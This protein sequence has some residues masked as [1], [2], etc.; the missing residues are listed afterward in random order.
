MKKLLFILIVCIYVIPAFAQGKLTPE[1]LWEFNRISD[2]RL[3]PDGSTVAYC[4]TNYDI[5]TNKRNTDI[6][7]V[8]VKDK[9]VQR[10]TDFEG[11]EFSPRWHPGGKTI[12]FLATEGGT[13]QLWITTTDGKMKNQITEIE[14]G[15]NSYEFSP[16]GTHIFYTK[17]IKL[18]KTT[19]EIY[20]DLPLANVKI[21][22]DL[23]YR[24][25]NDWT[26]DAY[27]HIFVADY[28]GK[29]IFNDKDIM[30]GEKW[31]SPLSPFF[32]E[33][34]ICWSPDGKIVAYTCKKLRG[35]DYAIST[36][37]D[38]YLYYLETGKTVNITQGMK[39][40]DK[41]PV[42]TPDSKKVTW[43]SME[44]PGYESDKE[45]L[46]IY[47][48]GSGKMN[49]LTKDFDRNV[50]N[51][52]WDDDGKTLYF[53]S[54]IN[55]TF[56]IWKMD[57][58]T[59]E[60]KQV[61][62]GKHNYSS[63]EKK[64]D[65]FIAVKESMSKAREVYILNE[66]DGTDDQLTFAN[67][68]IYEKVK[69]G[70]VEER[71]VKTTDGKEMLVWVIYPPDFDAQKKYPALLYCQGGP[72]GAVSQRF[73]YRWNY[74]LMAAH[75]YIIIAPNRRGLPTFGSEW[76]DQICGDYGGQNIKDYLSAVDEIKKEP[77]V[78]E[79]RLGAIGASYGGY[80]VFWLAGHHEK[81]FKAFISHCGL[82]NLESF[83]G[84][85][86]ESFFPNY[87]VGGA[88]WEDPAPK[89][90]NFSPHKYVQNWDTPILI[91]TGEYDFRVPYTESL[92]AFNAA[93]LRDVP[94]KLL[95]F[96]DETHFVAKPQN[97]I[98]WNREFFGW[99]DKWLK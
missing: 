78:D 67:K 8:S 25:W 74:Q 3:S 99:L 51:V 19:N 1:I 83:Y 36:N 5:K 72:H 37:S 68:D 7:L 13:V 75:G 62:K 12:S 93:R 96:P 60:I 98:L 26:D 56:Q 79:D 49:Y 28:D 2:A 14:G 21:I 39:G 18:E 38:I 94:A 46:F 91:I 15:I 76:N 24:H 71:W 59:L 97:S 58:S 48:L 86:E 55:A 9:S 82:F 33:S 80:S 87:D 27:S 95:Y 84:A 43:L 85:T 88:Y 44:T 22:N 34:E 81:R 30:E 45:R 65:V 64:G 29:K 6:F 20:P 23:M 73:H 54:G 35:R 63:I 16:D 77:Y 70:K 57:I 32:D 42:F 53:I 90:Y 47:D 10:L 69:M 31:D 50:S 52:T 11:S 89:G 61:T 66:K 4:I 41:H 92:Q 17:D 40:Y